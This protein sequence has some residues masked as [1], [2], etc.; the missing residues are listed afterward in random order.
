[1]SPTEKKAAALEE[2]AK[3]ARKWSA[4]NR[5]LDRPTRAAAA[6]QFEKANEMLQRE[7]WKY[8]LA[9]RAAEGGEGGHE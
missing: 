7:A 4:A 6:R 8:D 1:M 3:R 9:C 5:N 2:L